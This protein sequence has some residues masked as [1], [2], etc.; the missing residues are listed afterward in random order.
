MKI[1]ADG[2]VTFE[3]GKLRTD[4]ERHASF[5]RLA[6]PKLGSRQMD[7]I[8]RPEINNLLDKIED[9]RGTA[10]ADHTLAYLRRA[11]NWHAARS[12]DFLSLIVRGMAR[13]SAALAGR[14]PGAVGRSKLPVGF[15]RSSDDFLCGAGTS[16]RFD[17]RRKRGGACH[18]GRPT[19]PHRVLQA[20]VKDG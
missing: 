12:D 6:C 13:G 7:Q 17:N 11:F 16:E 15:D 18:R 5:K 9:E 3:D 20:G 19:P 14:L 2:N 8:K 1:D 10:I 4:A